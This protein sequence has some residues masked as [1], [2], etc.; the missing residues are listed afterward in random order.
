MPATVMDTG[1]HD[2]HRWPYFLPDGK[3]FLYLAVSHNNSRDPNTGVYFASLGSKES[4]LVIKGF[5]NA[6]YSSGRL[7]FVRDSTLMT[8]RFD[9]KTG[10]LDG[11]PEQLVE[12][13]LVDGTIWRAAFDAS[14]NGFLA[15]TSGGLVPS[16]AVWYDRS[17]KELGAAGDKAFNLTS[18]RLSPDGTRLATE[19]GDSSGEIWIY[20]LK[21]QVN[22]RL[23][24]GPGA[25]SGPVWSPD[26]QWVAYTRVG[27]NIN[28]YRKP[29]NG[30]GQEELLQEGSGTNRLATDWSPDGKSLLFAVGDLAATGQIWTLPLTGER[31]PIPLVNGGFVST[32]AR[33]SPDGRWIAYASYESGRSEVYVLP[34]GGGAGKWQISNAG[35]TQPV[36]HR[37]GKELFYW[38]AENTLVSVP[39][40][41]KAGIVEVGAA[42]TLFR[43]SY[44]VGTVGL[45]SPYDVTADG[46]RFIVVVTTE[47]AA[48]PITLVTNWTAELKHQ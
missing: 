1:K 10:V 9:P 6:L 7:L 32:S 41:L 37:G 24:F 29:S 36:W 18:V 2:S 35:G 16:Q 25:S 42:H 22:T 23:T 28:F 5:T 38:S 34:F 33:F 3:H 17:G 47:R 15:Y 20:D 46:Q 30:T 4:R 14:E 44:P 45:S 40:T 13:V 8:Q 31:K 26:G 27:G 11:K 12:D 43:L 19:S 21:R 39:I 48:R